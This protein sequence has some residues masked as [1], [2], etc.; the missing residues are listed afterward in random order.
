MYVSD[1]KNVK[2]RVTDNIALSSV[3][4]LLNG[5]EYKTYEGKDLEL[6]LSNENILSLDIESANTAQKLTV[7]Y[8]DMAGNLG[9][10]EVKDFYI[11][12]NMWIRFTTNKP[13]VVVVCLLILIIIGSVI[14][15]IVNRRNK[16]R[17]NTN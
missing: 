11:T 17:N 3:R 8:M 15:I 6:I 1:K 5:K 10:I 9:S 16:N 4:V 14:L 12:K 2:I 13:L 7:E